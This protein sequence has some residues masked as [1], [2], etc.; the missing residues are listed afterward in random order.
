MNNDPIY[1]KLYVLSV[2]DSFQDNK[3]FIIYG[4]DNRESVSLKNE[5][6]IRLQVEKNLRSISDV[7]ETRVRERTSELSRSYKKLQVKMTERMRV[8]EQIKS[9]IAEKEILIN[10]IL[11]RVKSNMNIIISLIQAQE[12]KSN[13]KAIIKKFRELSQR[14]RALLLVHNNLYLSINYSDVDFANFINDL[15][16]QLMDFHNRKDSVELKLELSEVF[17]DVDYAIPLATVVNE[18]ISNVLQ[19]AFTDY[20]IN[21]YPGKKRILYVSYSFEENSYE[22]S[23]CDNGKG[24]PKDFMINDLDTNGLP[25]TQIL[26]ADQINGNLEYSSSKEGTTFSI[27]FTAQE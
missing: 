17:L 10:E 20:S 19:H 12:K 13:K 11:N 5:I 15:A 16:Q 8:E 18:L 21:K 3:G 4:H 27:K 23:V 1:C 22:I 25:L 26:V 7:L 2:M 14:V 9:D 24:L 6:K